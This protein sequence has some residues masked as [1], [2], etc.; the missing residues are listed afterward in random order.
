MPIYN[1][2]NFITPLS[3]EVARVLK[4]FRFNFLPY[5]TISALMLVTIIFQIDAL[6]TPDRLPI[7]V[8]VSSIPLN[9]NSHN[10]YKAEKVYENK[11]E[12][13]NNDQKLAEAG[14]NL[15]E[16][17]PRLDPYYV[18]G[19]SFSL[20]LFFLIKKIHGREPGNLVLQLAFL[21]NLQ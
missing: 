5:A 20:P 9:V 6:L 3:I 7:L 18:T 11:V 10:K 13:H 16:A 15:A 8:L 2:Y 1:H 21:K 14:L 12:I 17:S 19:F 4:R